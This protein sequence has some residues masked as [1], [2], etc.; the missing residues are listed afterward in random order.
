MKI[1]IAVVMFLLGLFIGI[2]VVPTFKE[3]SNTMYGE[4][5]YSSDRIKAVLREF[6]ISSAPS[7][8]TVLNLFMKQDGEKKELWVRINCPAEARALF[9]EEL[10]RRRSGRFNGEE[11][12]APKKQDG[13]AILWWGYHDVSG[14]EEFSDLCVGYDDLNPYLFLYAVSEAGE[15]PNPPVPSGSDSEQK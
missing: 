8:A 10:S 12:P 5:E 3:F 9:V 1:L 11:P 15:N 13:S 2:L 7:E 6:G 4:E 14:K